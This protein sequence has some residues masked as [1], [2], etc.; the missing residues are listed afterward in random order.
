MFELITVVSLILLVWFWLNPRKKRKSFAGEKENISVK[1][2]PESIVGKSTFVLSTQKQPRTEKQKVPKTDSSGKIEIEIPLDHEPET[3]LIEEQ[4]E[5][6]K[7]GLQTEYSSNVTPDELMLVVNEVGNHQSQSAPETGKLL[8]ENENTD[9]VEQLSSS[10]VNS[11]NRI[12]SLIDLHLERL[13]Q[14]NS[15]VKTDDGL[16][17]FDIGEYVR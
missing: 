13:V 8:Y 7:L 10:S 9:W 17:E 12:S 1:Q 4:E 15:N 5:L 3:D 16:R 2:N 11:A 14:P 6:E